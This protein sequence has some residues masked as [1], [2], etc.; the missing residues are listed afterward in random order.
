MRNGKLADDIT[1]CCYCVHAINVSPESLCYQQN[2][3]VTVSSL[4]FIRM[5]TFTRI[6]V[7]I[8]SSLDS[9]STFGPHFRKVWKIKH[10]K[11]HDSL[12]GC[13]YIQL[14]EKCSWY[15]VKF[16]ICMRSSTGAFTCCRNV[17]C[18]NIIWIKINK[19]N[20]I[21]LLKIFTND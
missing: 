18:M 8:L 2:L 4:Q 16:I 21:L 11:P 12:V 13:R 15:V 7:G 9:G 20:L 5:C 10:L 1:R 3:S 17:T 6:N 19:N 14:N